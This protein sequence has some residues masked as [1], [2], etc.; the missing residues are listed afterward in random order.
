MNGC[1]I[2]NILLVE[3]DPGDVELTREGFK[4]A[5]MLIRLHTVD[6]GVK[7]MNFLRKEPPYTDAVRPDLILLDLN[8][9]RKNG[10]DVLHEIK[11]DENLKRTPVVVLTT[12]SADMDILKCYDLGANCYISKPVRFEDFIRVVRSIE[13]FWL[14]VVRTPPK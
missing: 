1:R 11:S 3:D 6:D 13:N 7:A 4:E 2:V 12:S 8:L 5:K 10:Q 14:T 9:P